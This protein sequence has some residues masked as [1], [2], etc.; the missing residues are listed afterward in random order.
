MRDI[1]VKVFRPARPGAGSTSTR[2]LRSLQFLATGIVHT[3]HIYTEGPVQLWD[4]KTTFKKYYFYL[5]LFFNY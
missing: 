2:T 5:K 1:A 3:S 4:M